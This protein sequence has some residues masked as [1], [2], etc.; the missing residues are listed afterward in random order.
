MFF[1]N[2][3]YSKVNFIKKLHEY[4]IVNDTIIRSEDVSV[5]NE[6]SN[7]DFLNWSIYLPSVNNIVLFTYKSMG[8]D[9]KSE[10]LDPKKNTVVFFNDKIDF[11]KK[12]G[13]PAS[14]FILN[15]ASTWH[16]LIFIKDKND[17]LYTIDKFT[18]N[19]NKYNSKGIL[20]YN[21]EINF[22]SKYKEINFNI[23]E[24]F[25]IDSTELIRGSLS[26]ISA[27]VYDDTKDRLLVSY[28]NETYEKQAD[29]KLIEKRN[30]YFIIFDT[31]GNNITKEPIIAP[32][33]SIPFYFDD[34]LIISSEINTRSQ[35]EIVKYNIL[36]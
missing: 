13:S 24:P 3:S 4:D 9:L 19:L 1:I 11:I 26:F 2:N 14:N 8:L 27:M 18:K 29:G 12:V 36:Y 16:S 34:N 23:S 15:S 7:E 33:N 20:T 6:K 21:K 31:N 30:D 28:F 25:P 35:L 10:M 17:N 32:V 5:V 22:G